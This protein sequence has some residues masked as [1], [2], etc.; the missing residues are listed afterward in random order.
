MKEDEQKQGVLRDHKENG[1]KSPPNPHHNQESPS[2]QKHS[3]SKKRVGKRDFEMISVLGKGSFGKVLLVEHKETRQ[4]YAM[5]VIKKCNIKKMNQIEHTI[6]ERKVLERVS[7]P[8]IV[9][10]RYAFKDRECL[11]FV[12][13]YCNGGELFF[14]I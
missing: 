9:K 6:T 13:D 11:Y 8:F 2:E 3:K 7:H 10:L 1:G 5:K 4:A 12:L 14:Y